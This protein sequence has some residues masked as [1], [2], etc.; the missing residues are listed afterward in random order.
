MYACAL[1]EK[2]RQMQGDARKTS[3]T[4]EEVEALLN[5]V[6]QARKYNPVTQGA[7]KCWFGP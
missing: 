2:T 5:G 4:F 6:N 3:K 7:E 1:K